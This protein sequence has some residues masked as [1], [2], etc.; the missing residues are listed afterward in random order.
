MNAKQDFIGAN[1]V[2]IHEWDSR[3]NDLSKKELT[4]KVDSLTNST[5]NAVLPKLIKRLNNATK[6]RGSKS[7]LAAWLG[8]HR[9]SVTDWLSR[10][11]EPGGEITL[12]LL[13]WVEQQERQK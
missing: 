3:K 1:I 9:Q 2:E 10:K 5:V 11:Q 6:S 4:E 7:K 12:K 8:V 13:Q